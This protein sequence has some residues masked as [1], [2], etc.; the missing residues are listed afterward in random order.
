MGPAGADGTTGPKGDKGS[1]NQCACC[2]QSRVV[3]PVPVIG[4]PDFAITSSRIGPHH[5]P[6]TNLILGK[7]PFELPGTAAPTTNA[8]STAS[9]C[10]TC[11]MSAPCG[12]TAG[13]H[14]MGIW[15]DSHG[16]ETMLKTGCTTCHTNATNLTTAIA[17]L[18]A[19]V[20]E[21]MA[22]LEAQLIAA[23][24]YNST[25]G[26]ANTGTF[27]ADAVLAYLNYNT[28]KEDRSNDAH[29]PEYIRVLL[30]NSITAMTTLG[31]P[32]P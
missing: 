10:I 30:D 27:K 29:N 26:L 17:N 20:T 22:T 16:T 8:H 19:D 32:A 1:S 11:H 2:H 18:T 25:T 4:G 23:G 31:Y 6:N 13:G 15:Y 5:G 21:R 7:T 3:S 28:I 24:I 12:Y 14:N 9:G